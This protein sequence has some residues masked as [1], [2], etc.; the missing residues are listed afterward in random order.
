[1]Y[2]CGFWKWYF[3]VRHRISVRFV[4]LYDLGILALN[5]DWLHNLAVCRF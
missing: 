4:D 5:S 1:M 3:G 2:T